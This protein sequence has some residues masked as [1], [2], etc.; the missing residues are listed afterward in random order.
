MMI[1]LKVHIKIMQR[2]LYCIL[3]RVRTNERTKLQSRSSLLCVP[4]HAA[5]CL[6]SIQLLYLNAGDALVPIK[7]G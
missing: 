2:V 1:R 7:G 3:N 4:G 6:D 5:S